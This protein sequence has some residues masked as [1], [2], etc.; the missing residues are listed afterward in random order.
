M[1]KVLRATES[2]RWD[3]FALGRRCS[4]A[5]VRTPTPAT[6]LTFDFCPLTCL[7]YCWLTAIVVC[8]GGCELE[9]LLSCTNTCTSV[10]GATKSGILTSICQMPTCPG[11]R[12]ENTMHPEGLQSASS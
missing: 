4:L 2:S 10:H 5:Y 9:M 8:C 11:A 1:S 7:F 6:L 3:S 12:P